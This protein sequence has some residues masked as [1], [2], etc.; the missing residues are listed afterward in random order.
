MSET[1]KRRATARDAGQQEALR[2]IA[3]MAVYEDGAELDELIGIIDACRAV[4]AGAI[5]PDD[6]DATAETYGIGLLVEEFGEV[7]QHLGKALRFGMDTPGRRVSVDRLAAGAVDGE[8]PRTLLPAELGDVLAAI[9]FVARHRL[10]DGG[11][12]VAAGDRKL[13]KLLDPRSRDNLGRPLAP[14]PAPMARRADSIEPGIDPRWPGL[15][16]D[17]KARAEGRNLDGSA[18]REAL[19]EAAT[20]DG[21]SAESPSASEVTLKDGPH[22]STADDR[23]RHYDRD[24][25]CDNPARGY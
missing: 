2:V 10:V 23:S 6:C 13:A 14:Q 5:H 17:A 21:V 19:P 12:I 3:T 9:E 11:K 8:T 16:A 24:G 7:L 1:D 18:R 4:A 15:Y 20:A 22:A 25:Y